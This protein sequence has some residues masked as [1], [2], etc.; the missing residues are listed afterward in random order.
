MRVYGDPNTP[1]NQHISRARAKRKWENEIQKFK[2]Y[3]WDCWQSA[4]D[5]VL[6]RIK[7]NKQRI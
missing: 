3:C 1:A 6:V 2:L 5:S 4:Q 7:R